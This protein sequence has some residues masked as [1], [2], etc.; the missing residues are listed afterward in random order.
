[1]V[2]AKVKSKE[3]EPDYAKERQYIEKLKERI[4]KGKLYWFYVLAD[5][6]TFKPIPGTLESM[7]NFR[8][9]FQSKPNKYKNKHLAEVRIWTKADSPDFVMSI[10]VI[11]MKI[12][13]KGDIANGRDA[14]SWGASVDW[15]PQ[16]LRECKFSLKLVQR[17]IQLTRDKHLRNNT[18]N[19]HPY[20]SVVEM[21]KKKG[22]SLTEPIEKP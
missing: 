9:V 21:L 6:K 18:F 13:E 20:P 1:M 12:T 3:T 19:S 2:T 8:R 11:I 15:E 5:Q 7:D 22:M 4:A 10:K 16:H 17:L 14:F